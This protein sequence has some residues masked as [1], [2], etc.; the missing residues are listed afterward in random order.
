MW[1]LMGLL[2]TDVSEERVGSIFR[3]EENTSKEKC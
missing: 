3:V 2:Q 1:R